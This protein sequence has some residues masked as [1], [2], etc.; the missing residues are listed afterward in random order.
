MLWFACQQW[1][2]QLF[3]LMAK[4]FSVRIAKITSLW[5]SCFRTSGKG[6]NRLYSKNPLE[7]TQGKAVK[8]VIETG[9]NEEAV[10]N[11]WKQT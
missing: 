5:S 11:S 10:A 6:L 8:K 9:D 4:N 2:G 3:F 1:V 7:W